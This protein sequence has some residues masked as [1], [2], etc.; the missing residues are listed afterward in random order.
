M[1]QKAG[2]ACL[3]EVQYVAESRE[4]IR[5]ERSWMR[6]QL[7]ELSIDSYASKANFLFVMTDN[8]IFDILFRE[9]IL[10]RDCSNF[11]GV[12]EGFYRIALRRHEDNKELLSILKREL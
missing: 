12:G 11:R 5:R 1:A 2:L 4:F 7:R 9:R 8:P 10:I 3:D 6:D